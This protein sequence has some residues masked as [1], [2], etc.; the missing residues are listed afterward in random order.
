MLF[1]INALFVAKYITA[2]AK[3]IPVKEKDS[4]LECCRENPVQ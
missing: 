1:K 4:L 3:G 2:S